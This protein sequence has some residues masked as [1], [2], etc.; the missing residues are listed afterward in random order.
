MGSDS[1][2]Y[3]QTG[4]RIKLIW[5]GD[6]YTKLEKGDMGTIQYSFDNAGTRC[7]AIR[8]DSGSNLMLIADIINSAY[9]L[10]STIKK[11]CYKLFYPFKLSSY[12]N[13]GCA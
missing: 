12:G 4:K 13:K 9:N 6:K 3:S 7:I 10:T 5:S 1:F 8:W 2:D 11:Y